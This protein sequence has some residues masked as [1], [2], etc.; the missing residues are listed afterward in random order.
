MT[1]TFRSVSPYYGRIVISAKFIYVYLNL[2]FLKT[3]KNK[4]SLHLAI[5][6]SPVKLFSQSEFTGPE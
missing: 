6:I 2:N 5:C 3:L 1:C 4:G